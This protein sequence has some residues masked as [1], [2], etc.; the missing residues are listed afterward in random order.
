MQSQSESP[1]SY[2]IVLQPRQLETALYHN[3]I[4]VFS[5]DHGTKLSY[6]HDQETVSDIFTQ[7][8]LV[9]FLEV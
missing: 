6:I 5:L 1:G 7:L 2:R 8:S 4:R 3:Q 9:N